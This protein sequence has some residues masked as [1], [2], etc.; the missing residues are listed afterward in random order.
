L[1]AHLIADNVHS[2]KLKVLEGG[3]RWAI[4]IALSKETPSFKD[5][6]ARV[7]RGDVEVLVSDI[8]N[9]EKAYKFATAVSENNWFALESSRQQLLI[10]RDLGFRPKEV[11]AA[12]NIFNQALEKIE[13]PKTRMQS[14]SV[15]LFS[16]HMIDTPGR[17]DPRFPNDQKYI[18]IAAN[19]IAAK[20]YE[21]GAGQGDIAL[22][23]GACG[24]DLLFAESSL[25]RGL[26]LQIRIPFEEPVF[27]RKSVSFAGDIWRDKFYK[28]KNNPNTKLY[29]MPDEIGVPPKGVDIYARNNLWQL[30]TALSLG[31]ERV[32]F[33]CL[34]NRKGDDGP[35]GTKDM[36]EQISKHSGHAYVLNTNEL[37]KNTL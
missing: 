8:P 22:C 18:D 27:L 14:K 13:K 2:E 19:A 32:R 25:E 28:V 5:Y 21:L 1:R 17:I 31:Y 36:Y 34:W 29:V 10:L 26:Y 24:G 35:G 37:F 4:E 9:I 6:W 11:E 30:Y 20:L 7:T 3:V 12:I 15:F 23:G 33:I 16:G